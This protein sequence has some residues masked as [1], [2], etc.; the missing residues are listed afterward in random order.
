MK[1]ENKLSLIFGI[2]LIVAFV[3][4][5]VLVKFID[6]KAIGPN[7][8]SVGFAA[9]NEFV[10]N[11][12]GV[13]WVMYSITDWLGIVAIAVA[14]GFA[15]FGLV[16]LIIRKSL[17]KVD[18]NILALGVFYI[19]V[20]AIYVLFEF[21]VVNYRPTLIDGRLEA[22]YPSSTTM[23]ILCIMPTA[24]MQFNWHIKNKPLKISVISVSAAFTAFT[25]IGRIVSGVHWISDI[26]GGA[27]FSVGI[28]LIYY[29]FCKKKSLNS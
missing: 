27:L 23:L 21:V 1:K 6:V 10:H 3:L 25:V 16:Q 28:V 14:A 26:I 13:N 12:T 11:L 22:S 24:I 2:C 7:N 17:R 15:I 8:S 9:F 4:W 19:A 18:Y 29:Y 20:I 5:T